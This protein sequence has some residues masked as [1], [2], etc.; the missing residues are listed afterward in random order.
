VTFSPAAPQPDIR[1][2]EYSGLDTSA[3]FD[4]AQGAIGTGTALSTGNITTATANELLVAGNEIGHTTTAPGAGFTQRLITSPNSHILEDRIVTTAGSYSATATQ[5]ISGFWIIQVVAFKAAGGGGGG[6]TQA[7]TVPTGLSATP[8]S[9]TQVNL[10]W[11]AST[12]NVGVTGYQVQRCQGAGCTNFADL[13][14]PSGT[15]FNDT[16]RSPNTTYRYQVRAR[17]AVPNWSAYSSPVSATTPADSTAPSVPTGLAATAVSDTQINVTWNASSDNVAVTGYQLQRCQGSGCTNF[18]DL[19]TP[20]GTSFSDTGRTPNTTYRYQVRA[21]DAVPNWSAYSSPVSATTQTDSAAPSV[22]TG[23]TATA[24][25]IS[26][27]NVSWNASTD[28]VGVTGYQLQRCQGAGCTNF[29][30]LATPSG[31]SFNNTGLS[32]NTTYRYQVRAR[33]A[34]PNWSSYSSPAAATTQADSTAPSVPTGLSATAV[35]SS[36]INLSWNASTDN[37]A[38]TGYQLQRCQGVG[39][40]SF[41]DL[42][43]PSGTSFNDTGLSASTT[44]RYQVRARDAVPNWSA[45]SS[46]VSAATQA[47]ADTQAPTAPASLLI[48]AASSNEIDLVWTGSTDNVGVT[49]YIVERCSGVS[50]SNWGSAGTVST[51]TPPATLFNNTSLSASTSYSYRVYARDAANNPSAPSNVVTY[52]TPANSPDCN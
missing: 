46:P 27:I 16:G 36:Q 17:D 8:V 26:Q 30:D 3:P 13:A 33:D 18:A 35:S 49:A 10:S 41:A 24:V 9:A 39:C 31:T 47:P 29:T 52:Q 7:P 19:A 1:I 34:V 44:Y 38:V 14:T 43:T 15:T 32:P 40:T 45:Y 5:N 23:L 21:R 11:T 37:V 6:D 2:A 20:S 4:V 50:C 51:P 12:D 22:P 48:V 25:S 42:A 28:N